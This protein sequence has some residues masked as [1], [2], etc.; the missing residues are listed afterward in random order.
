VFKTKHKEIM[1]TLNIA[2]PMHAL[3][4]KLF[5]LCLSMALTLLV[6]CNNDEAA[7]DFSAEDTE[8]AGTDAVE[9]TYFED[10]DDMMTD[11]LEEDDAALSGGKVSTDERFACASRERLGTK[12]AG[13]LRVDFG[14]GCTDPRGNI[15]KGVIM[16]EHTGRWNTPGSILN[17]SYE[18]YSI[19]GLTMEG[20]RRVTVLSVVD[21]TTTYDVVLTGG[22][23]T[24]P[25]GRVATRE[26]N[27]R[28]ERE[29]HLNH[30]LDR[31]IIYGTAQGTFRNGRGYSIE[32][33]ERLIYTHACLAEGV[34]IPV[35][36]V[37]FI[38]H[39]DRELTVDYGDG[40]C[41]NIVTLT[42]KN[43]RTV[44]CEVGK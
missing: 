8:S 2:R 44:R 10:A 11:A 34:I 9:D 31:L 17:I 43:G 35:S 7:P 25:D 41:D 37:K 19:N 29:R 12:E 22:K 26:V 16:V 32:I 21:S 27:H 38:K 4:E 28:R 24:W 36:G 14:E 3:T 20:N 30:L 13:S 18:N 6:S 42:N 23:I 5:I 33:L 15:R 40:T 1:K 39:G